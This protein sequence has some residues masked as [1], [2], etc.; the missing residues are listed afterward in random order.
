MAEIL[1]IHISCNA[2]NA[3]TRSES[4]SKM[5]VAKIQ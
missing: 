1:F 5:V 3:I 4:K 2:H